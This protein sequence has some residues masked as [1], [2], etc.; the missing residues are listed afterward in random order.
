[1]AGKT[2]KLGRWITPDELAAH[3]H[4]GGLTNIDMSSVR[5]TTCGML[6]TDLAGGWK[7]VEIFEM[8]ND[9]PVVAE[10]KIFPMPPTKREDGKLLDVRNY[11]H[12]SPES[13]G[14]V[15]PDGGVKVSL[16]REVR[17]GLKHAAPIIDDYREWLINNKYVDL[18][19]M[20]ER[21]DEQIETPSRAK[22]GERR[23]QTDEYYATLAMDYERLCREGSRS[24]V[25]TMA[26][27]RAVPIAKMSSHIHRARRNGF[28]SDAVTTAAGGVATEKALKILKGES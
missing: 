18:T 22:T 15:T 11:G 27:E 6:E 16:L 1:M 10:L 8:Q 4:T 21:L 7:L 24:P 23:R 2:E 17:L 25:K 20:A 14:D 12:R 9:K 28:L 3:D 13:N 5:E 26:E 19:G